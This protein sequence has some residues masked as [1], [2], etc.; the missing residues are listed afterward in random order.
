MC[1]G[2]RRAFYIPESKLAS[3][4]GAYV[5]ARK[6]PFLRVLL[7][8]SSTP[9]GKGWVFMDNPKENDHAD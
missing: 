6:E 4:V 5:R 2:K 9:L 3:G 7:R 1:L 8:R